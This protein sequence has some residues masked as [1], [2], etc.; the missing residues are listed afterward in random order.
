MADLFGFEIKKKNKKEDTFEKGRSFVT[1]QDQSGGVVTAGGHFSQYLDLSAEQLSDDASQIRKYREIATVPE[2]DQAITD[3]VSESIVGDSANPITLNVDSLD[4]SDK[5]KKIFKEEF[6]NVL[7]LLSF[8][9][10]GHEMFRKWYVDGRIY[11][12]ILIDEKN[13]KKGILELRP[14]ESTRITKVKEVIRKKPILIQG[15]S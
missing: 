6:A 4:Q 15:Q 8:N 5:I 13:P 12:H 11:Y 10:Y 9:Q 2:C 7:S 14:I 3:I 1:P